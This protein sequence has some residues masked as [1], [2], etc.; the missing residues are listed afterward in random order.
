VALQELLDDAIKVHSVAYQR[1][2]VDLVRDFDELPV[3][4]IDKHKVFQ[5]VINLL[6]NAKHAC[7]AAQRDRREVILRLKRIN[8]ERCKIEVRDNGVGIPPENL[9]RIFLQGFTTKTDGH[10]FGLHS[11]SLAAREIGGTLTAAS[12]GPDRGATFTLELP[13]AT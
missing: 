5:I 6:S 13:L 9:L 8:G 7:D 10:G 11:A 1:H 3:I 2:Q 4:S 12:D